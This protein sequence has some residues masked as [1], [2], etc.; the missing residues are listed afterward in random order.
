MKKKRLAIYAA[1]VLVFAIACMAHIT[2]GLRARAYD[3]AAAE[4]G[5]ATLADEGDTVFIRM[6]K[7]TFG[8][9]DDAEEIFAPGFVVAD[10][11]EGENPAAG[12][13]LSVLTPI[14]AE[15]PLTGTLDKN[16]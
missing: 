5:T 1:L 16:I 6:A 12:I 3:Y 10:A 11:A 2:P 15:N 9:G 4:I 14:T 7:F 13:D 8:E